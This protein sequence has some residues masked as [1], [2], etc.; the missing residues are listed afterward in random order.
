MRAR[1]EWDERGAASLESLPLRF[2]QDGLQAAGGD[3]ETWVLACRILDAGRI[4][5][6]EQSRAEQSRAERL[7]DCR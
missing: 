7:R 6:A 4:L 2:G 1:R 5:W 3:R